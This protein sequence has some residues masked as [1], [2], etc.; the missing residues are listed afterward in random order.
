[1]SLSFIEELG[2]R[3]EFLND[4]AL[5]NRVVTNTLHRPYGDSLHVP[6]IGVSKKKWTDGLDIPPRLDYRHV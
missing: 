6:V 1:M 2:S 5:E 4:L 3:L